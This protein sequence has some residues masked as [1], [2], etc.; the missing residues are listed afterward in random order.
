MID[1][2]SVVAKLE[3]AGAR[4]APLQRLLDAPH[5]VDGRYITLRDPPGVYFILGTDNP[6][7][8]DKITDRV[9]LTFL[10][11]PYDVGK[12]AMAIGYYVVG[13]ERLPVFDYGGKPHPTHAPVPSAIL[14]PL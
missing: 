11:V 9:Q 5:I 14:A 1:L 2:S 7:Q 6:D 12:F 3:A 10:D 13:T 8:Q 4:H